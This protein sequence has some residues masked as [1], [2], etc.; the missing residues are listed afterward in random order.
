M[1]RCSNHGTNEKR[2]RAQKQT[3]KHELVR[4]VGCGTD[5]LNEP[6][7]E[8]DILICLCCGALGIAQPKED[9]FDGGFDFE[10]SRWVRAKPWLN[11]LFKLV[12]TQANDKGIWFTTQYATEALLQQELRCLHRAIEGT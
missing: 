7:K 2:S 12:K 8:G 4:P 1:A 11:E 6:L 3:H 9:M 10:G 5:S